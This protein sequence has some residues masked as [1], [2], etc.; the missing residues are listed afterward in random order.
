MPDLPVPAPPRTEVQPPGVPSISGLMTLAV[1][2][3]VLAALY[4]GREVFLPIVFAVLLGFVIAPFVDLMRR[5]RLGRVPSVIIAV[6]VALGI[7][8]SL[9][10]IIGLQV[11]GPSRSEQSSASRWRGSRLI[12]PSTKAQCARR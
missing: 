2:V 1:S 3:V 10:T 4:L 12:C 9:G 5:W 6:V 7:V 11:A 8:L